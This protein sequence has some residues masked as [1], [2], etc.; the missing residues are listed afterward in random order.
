MPSFLQS[1]ET[2]ISS[3]VEPM[4]VAGGGDIKRLTTRA[5]NTADQVE[6]LLE[7]FKD[8]TPGAF[9]SLPTVA[10]EGTGTASN[11]QLCRINAFVTYNLAFAT[12]HRGYEAA[13]K[14]DHYD[15]FDQVMREYAGRMILDADQPATWK[16]SH[17]VMLGWNVV[18]TKELA[19]SMFQF[20]IKY[21]GYGGPAS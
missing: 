14:V 19:I 9:L 6:Q 7:A 3:Y 12:M 13:K 16:G 5:F 11:A 18:T 17:I 8:N 1:V 15:Y 2:M 20:S 10:F 21:F 4:L